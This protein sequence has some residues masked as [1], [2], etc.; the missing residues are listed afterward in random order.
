MVAGAAAV[1]GGDRGDALSASLFGRM[2]GPVLIDLFAGGG[3][4]SEGMRRATGFH[5]VVA[6]NHCDDAIRM[7]AA[8]HPETMHFRED[9]FKVAPGVGSRGRR[10][11]L[12]W[13]SPQCTHFSRARG[14]APKSE[15]QRSLAWVV[16]DWARDVR[17]RCIIVENVPEFVTWGPLGDDGEPIRERAGET[18]AAWVSALEGAGYV[19][20][21]RV[22]TAANYGAPTT[23][24]R[25]YVIAT[26]DRAPAWPEPTHG[27]GRTL[28]WRTA[29]ECID[30]SLPCPSIFE[31]D[32]PLAEATLRRIAEGVR[33]FVVEAPAPFIA[34]V[35]AA[36]IAKHYGN[37]VVGHPADRPLGAVTA[38]DHHSL[39]LTKL[40]PAL[41]QTG[42]GERDGQSPRVLDLHAPLGSVVAGGQKHALAVAFLDKLYGSARAGQPLTEPM[43]TITSG[44]G[45]GGGHAG[46][47]YAFLTAYYGT[48]IG[49]RP[50]GPL[51][52]VVTK[53]RFG[54]IVVHVNGEPHVITDIGMRMLQPRELAR[55]QGFGEDY[56]LTGSKSSQVARIGNSVCPP[57][58]EA[59]VRANLTHHRR[60]AA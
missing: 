6:V 55:A 44:G 33:R 49:H 7:H 11:D 27:P 14:R 29:A 17:P 26:L 22:L 41:I 48:A 35:G 15:Q 20:E 50:D 18:F 8:N 24:R 2:D 39:V 57:V 40:S 43:P 60:A 28:P 32:K 51:P 5:P 45:K 13:A 36:W 38:V 37:G 25:V 23:R 52:S 9:V 47:V 58:A 12:L 1:G 46:L 54:L 16:V 53:D 21:H 42:Y 10:P 3:G 56:I 4:A 34:P 30:W 19:V 59:L 31:R